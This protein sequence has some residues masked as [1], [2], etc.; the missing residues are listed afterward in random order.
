MTNKTKINEFIRMLGYLYMKN[1]NFEITKDT[2]YSHL[3]SFNIKDGKYNPVPKMNIEI[4][5][6]NIAKNY[7]NNNLV[8][9]FYSGGKGF[10]VIENRENL[11]DYDFYDCIEDSIK[12]YVSI[13]EENLEYVAKEVFNFMVNNNI[14][15]Q[16]KISK[17]LRVDALVLRVY[18]KE[19]ANN[20]INFINSLNYQSK[21]E[22]N[23]FLLHKDKVAVAQDGRLSFNSVLSQILCEYYKKKRKRKLLSSVCFDDFKKFINYEFNINDCLLYLNLEDEDE[24]KDFHTIHSILAS[25]INNID[26]IDKINFFDT[27]EKDLKR[28]DKQANKEVFMT[29]FSNMLKIYSLENVY[30]IFEQYIGTGNLN[31]F[32]RQNE[33]RNLVK[34]NFNGEMLK[35]LLCDFVWKVMQDAYYFTYE[36]YGIK[37]SDTAIDKLFSECSYKYFTNANNAR[38]NL[39]NYVLPSYFFKVCNQKCLEEGLETN[40]LSVKTI[41]ASELG[42]V[43]TLKDEK[44]L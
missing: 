23:P 15:T 28:K 42:I 33:I 29:L 16:S 43:D 44:H 39:K 11:S 7:A 5:R 26:C 22:P 19:Q 2:I 24:I 41:L 34:N 17:Y 4:I 20:V 18:G 35:K 12:I 40:S 36:K 9:T 31:Y 30:A 8:N 13:D 21:Y 37:Q 27:K 1:P 25:N 3:M 38:N 32:T 10:F 14:I 6:E